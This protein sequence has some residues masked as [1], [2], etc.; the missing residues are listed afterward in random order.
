MR[1]LSTLFYTKTNWVYSLVAFLATFVY[2]YLVMIP[3]S[4]VYATAGEEQIALATSFGFDTELVRSFLEPLNVAQLEAYISFNLIWDNIFALI[5]GVMYT[6]WLSL[7]FK[8]WAANQ[9][10]L[11]CY[12]S[13][14]PFSTG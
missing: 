10:C 3:K 1:K 7:L 4:E 2:L 5:Y 11:I 14:N 13:Y 6:F 8:P 9:N 12:Q